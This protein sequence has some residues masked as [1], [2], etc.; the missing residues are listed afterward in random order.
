MSTLHI[1]KV[2]KW[3]YGIKHLSRTSIFSEDVPRINYP[4]VFKVKVSRDVLEKN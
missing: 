2:M 4:K 1:V 3:N